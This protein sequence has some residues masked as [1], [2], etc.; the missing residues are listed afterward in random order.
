MVA[1]ARFVRRSREGPVR[2]RRRRRPRRVC[3]HEPAAAPAS[4]LLVPGPAPGFRRPWRPPCPAPNQRRVP[5]GERPPA[6]FA[7]LELLPTGPRARRDRARRRRRVIV[8]R[9]SLPSRRAR[10]SSRST[11]RRPRLV[12]HTEDRRPRSAHHSGPPTGWRP[13]GV[14]IWRTVAFKVI[15]L[16]PGILPSPWVIGVLNLRV[17]AFMPVFLLRAPLGWF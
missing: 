12:T 13:A 4:R 14:R 3:P 1:P 15:C 8:M 17:K 5:L 10:G 6:S 7:V 16:I 11:D 2:G 9:P